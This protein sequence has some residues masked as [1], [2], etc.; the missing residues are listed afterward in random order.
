MKPHLQ[1][2]SG[3]RSR[4]LCQ[5]LQKEQKMQLPAL[6]TTQE[7]ATLDLETLQKLEKSANELLWQIKRRR[8]ELEPKSKGLKEVAKNA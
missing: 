2:L 5:L 6:P 7:L 3:S 1:I 4:A 8:M